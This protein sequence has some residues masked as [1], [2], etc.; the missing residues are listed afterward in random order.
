MKEYEQTGLLIQSAIKYVFQTAFERQ[1]SARNASR[2]PVFIFEDEAAHFISEHDKHFQATAR[3]ARVSRVVIT[4]NVNSFYS[5]FSQAVT[6]TIFGNL[7]TKIF[8]QNSD[9]STNFFASQIFGNEIVM[10]SSMSFNSPKQANDFV[11]QLYQT[12]LPESSVSHSEAEH[13]EPAVRPE[14]F[15][16]LRNGGPRNNFQVEAYITWLGMADGGGRHFTKTTFL[17]QSP[18]QSYE[19]KSKRQSRILQFLRKIIGSV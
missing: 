5:E 2:R 7:N 11:G 3:S 16:K 18:N 6:N 8:H 9:T 12:Y 10:R 13:L 1:A 19:R 15:N 14:E 4:Q 17:Q